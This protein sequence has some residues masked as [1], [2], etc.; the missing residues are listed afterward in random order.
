ML[1][2]SLAGS[3]FIKRFLRNQLFDGDLKCDFGW[4]LLEG[5]TAMTANPTFLP[6]VTGEM[7]DWWFAWH[8]IDRLR[9]ACW[10]NEDHYDVY[11]EDPARARNMSLSIRERHWGSIHHIWEDIGLP[12]G[13]GRLIISFKEPGEMGYDV[14][15]IDTEECNSLV[16]ANVIIMGDDQAPDLP[17]VM[18]H[19]LKPVEGGSQLQSVFWFG[20]Q[21]IDGKA[22][23]CIPEGIVIPKAGPISLL[24]HNVKEFFNLAKILAPIYKEEKDNWF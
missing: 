2:S 7:F 1:S 10:D 3:S 17:V 18:T 11:L 22:V 23:K 15:R 8:P 6:G 9:Y 19:F 20:W 5:G 13:A 12:G 16:C 14:S 21:I 4:W 24:K